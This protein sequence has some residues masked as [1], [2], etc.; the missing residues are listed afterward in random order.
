[1]SLFYELQLT[2]IGIPGNCF[3]SGN[4]GCTPAAASPG[5]RADGDWPCTRHPCNFRL[6]LVSAATFHEWKTALL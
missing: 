1:V 3:R 4:N 2:D 5:Y 6:L